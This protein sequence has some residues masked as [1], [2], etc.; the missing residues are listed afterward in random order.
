MN[1]LRGYIRAALQKAQD[2]D[3]AQLIEKTEQRA[4]W[5]TAEA[6]D[7]GPFLRLAQR[8]DGVVPRLMYLKS[9]NKNPRELPDIVFGNVK[10][11]RHWSGRF[12]TGPL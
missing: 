11:F 2:F 12:I 4:A 3:D 5:A 7:M 10:H 6:D 1:G 9:K 8:F